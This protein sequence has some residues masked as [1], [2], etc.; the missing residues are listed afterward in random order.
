MTMSA[1]KIGMAEKPAL[2][3]RDQFAVYDRI[4]TE[5]TV[6]YVRKV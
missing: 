6:D 4:S 2:S 5:P 3:R 1:I